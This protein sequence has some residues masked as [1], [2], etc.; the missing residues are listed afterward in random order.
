LIATRTS[1]PSRATT[2]VSHGLDGPT[3]VI[4]ASSTDP[5]VSP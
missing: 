4:D 5:L 2:P 1:H 3:H